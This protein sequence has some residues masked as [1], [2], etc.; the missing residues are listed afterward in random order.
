[1][2]GKNLACGP[3]KAGGEGNDAKAEL[4]SGTDGE[5]S[6]AVDAGNCLVP[7]ILSSAKDD[8]NKTP[9]R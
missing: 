6:A 2:G 3:R 1:V 5:S 9:R 7:G 8:P 4:G